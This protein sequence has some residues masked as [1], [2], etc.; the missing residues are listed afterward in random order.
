VKAALGWLLFAA[1]VGIASMSA[2]PS[3]ATEAVG[4]FFIRTILPYFCGAFA[5][6]VALIQIAAFALAILFAA[7]VLIERFQSRKL[8]HAAFSALMLLS[9]LTIWFD[10]YLVAALNPLFSAATAEAVAQ[11]GVSGLANYLAMPLDLVATVVWVF[12]WYVVARETDAELDESRVRRELSQEHEKLLQES[13][14][15]A[16]SNEP[17]VVAVAVVEVACDACGAA[18]PST[19]RHCSRCGAPL[20][21]SRTHAGGAS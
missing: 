15:P 20:R 7:A 18:M 8:A 14:L 16:P 4:S 21:S 9:L 11:A 10:A 5:S 1:M 2:A 6:G 12:A 17:A 3:S 13:L 19:N